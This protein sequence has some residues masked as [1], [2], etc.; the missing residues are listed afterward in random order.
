MRKYIISLAA[1]ASIAAFA[2][3]STAQNSH[4]PQRTSYGH[5]NYSQVRSL[6][7]RIDG[8]QRRIERLDQRRIISNREAYQFRSQARQVERQLQRAARS[9]VNR[10]EHANLDS[11]MDRLELRLQR[12][13]THR[14]RG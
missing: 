9:G 5:N 4:A 14:N 7:V 13:A 12:E 10:V 2:G 11:R 6:Q 8:I 1:V 3:P